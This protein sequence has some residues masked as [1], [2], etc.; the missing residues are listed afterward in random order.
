MHFDLHL[1]Q[2]KVTENFLPEKKPVKI[3]IT[4]GASCPDAIVEAVI[5]RICELVPGTRD[6]EGILTDL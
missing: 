4:S 2:E 1:H 5:G 3:L 6:I